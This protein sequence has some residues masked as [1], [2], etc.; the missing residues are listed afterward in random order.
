MTNKETRFQKGVSG[1][2]KGARNKAT[3]AADSLLDGKAEAITRRCIDI[4]LDSDFNGFTAVSKSARRLPHPSVQAQKT[5]IKFVYPNG[6][7]KKKC[8]HANELD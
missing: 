7:Q 2:P 8:M 1:R 5:A 4:A 6:T 3:V